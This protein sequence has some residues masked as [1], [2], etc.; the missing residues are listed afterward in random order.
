MLKLSSRYYYLRH[1]NEI[2]RFL[3]KNSNW[4]HIIN[5]EN[6]FK[7]FTN[8]KENLFL[9]D[10]NSNLSKQIQTIEDQ[11]FDLIIITDIFEVTDDI[12]GLL[13]SLNKLL[14]NNGKILINSI[15]TK[16]NFFLLFFEFFKI[17]K[18]S[19]PRSYIHLKKIYS[20]SESSGFEMVKSFTRQI[21]PFRL[22]GI[23]NLLNTILEII[24][25]K[26][27]IGINNYLLLSKTNKEQKVY[28]KTIIV[29]AKNEELNLEPIINRIPL[30]ESDY[31]ILLVCAKSSDN[32]VE[33][34]YEIQQKYKN[35]PI[36]IIEQK[37]KGKGPGVLEAIEVSNFEIITIL[38]SDL[39]VDPETLNEFFEIIENGRADFV[40]GTRFVYKMEEGAMRKLN[41]IGNLFFQYIISI[42]ISTKLTDSLCGTKVFKKD[43][44]NQMSEWKSTLFIKDP[45][46]DFDFI[47]SAAYSGHKILEY[48]V[49]YRARVYGTTQISRFSDGI[50]LLFYFIN[51]LIMFNISKNDKK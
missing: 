6:S 47:F 32:T 48:P 43:L 38:D 49:H 50:K 36:K 24:F 8:S 2:Q 25:F 13:N 51:S 15:N 45:F 28:S 41:S 5:K 11:K 10:L 35:L 34:A 23:G 16:W 18:I 7:N 12:Y 44:I 29:P 22:F 33:T 27:N 1:E 30:F 4:I 3:S 39:S 40:N 42:V 46:G 19:R 31:E 14:T 17:K 9:I 21:F 37:T 26:F 20:I